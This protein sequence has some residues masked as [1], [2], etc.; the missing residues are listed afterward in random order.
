MI[1]TKKA[2][3]G[4]DDGEPRHAPAPAGS[5]GSAAPVAP[6]R[7]QQR[8]SAAAPPDRDDD[9]RQRPLAHQQRHQ[10]DDLARI[11]EIGRIE[12][13]A[14]IERFLVADRGQQQRD[15]ARRTACRCGAGRTARRSRSAAARNR[16][17]VVQPGRN[18]CWKKASV[19]LQRAAHD[20]FDRKDQDSRDAA[21]VI[22]QRCQA[23]RAAAAGAA[24]RRR[25]ASRLTGRRRYG[26]NSA[27]PTQRSSMR[28]K[29]V[30]RP[31]MVPS[32][33]ASLVWRKLRSRPARFFG[34]AFAAAWNLAR[35]S[36]PLTWRA[37]LRHRQS[38]R[39][40]RGPQSWPSHSPFRGRAARPSAWARIW[41]TRFP[42]RGAC[43]TRSTTR[44]ARS[45]RS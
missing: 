18:G 36:P 3:A 45:C 19:W 6:E 7:D 24:L 38:Q 31:V 16:M 25:C 9:G 40:S 15:R 27:L 26:S 8:N 43:S 2:S 10:F 29:T 20:E 41:P 4:S 17:T 37:A 12:R 23:R 13:I 14:E 22:A 42:R 35:L 5:P 28:N 39:T 11:E 21:S 34:C 1:D 33:K 32:Q 30:M 44:S